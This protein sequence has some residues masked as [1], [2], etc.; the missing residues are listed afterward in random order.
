MGTSIT[1]AVLGSALALVDA[2]PFAPFALSSAPADVAGVEVVAASEVPVYVRPYVAALPPQSPRTVPF[3]S[4][5]DDISSP[6]WQPRS[7]GI[8]S[9]AMLI[10]HYTRGSVSVDA[11]LYEG[12]AIGGYIDNVGWKH[13]ALVQ[14]AVRHGLSGRAYD[15]AQTS[16]TV[17]LEHI[18]AALDTGPVIASVHYRFD[19]H[20]GIP[21]LVVITDM[22]GDTVF[23][24][25]PADDVGGGS[26][27]LDSF[28][29]G[30]KKRYIE[31]RPGAA[32]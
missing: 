24:N 5:F 28:K 12:I 13:N 2:V 32:T 31:I 1:I 19:I 27:S 4:Q 23:Y 20:S 7:C 26:I 8:A 18:R 6:V 10:E 3:Y 11:L 16:M 15:Y 14:L 22:E 30:W 25:D 9:A 21:H 29:R 17:A